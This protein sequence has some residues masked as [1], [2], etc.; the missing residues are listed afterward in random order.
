MAE[1]KETALKYLICFEL[2]SFL[3]LKQCNNYLF[4]F[5]WIATKKNN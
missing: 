5:G 1:D 3:L 2:Q 4:L